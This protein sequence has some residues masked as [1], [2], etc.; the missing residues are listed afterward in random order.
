MKYLF[1]SDP[2]CQVDP[3]GYGGVLNCD[4]E[5]EI[6]LGLFGT[7]FLPLGVRAYPDRSTIFERRKLLFFNSLKRLLRVRIFSAAMVWMN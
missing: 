6:H 3:L 4:I 7:K 2:F 5:L 1:F